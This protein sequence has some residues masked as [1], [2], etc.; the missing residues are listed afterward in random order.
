MKNENGAQ[1]ASIQNMEPRSSV[2]FTA[3]F[4]GAMKELVC[5]DNSADANIMGHIVKMDQK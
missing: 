1:R 3:A 4:A 5:A 2:V